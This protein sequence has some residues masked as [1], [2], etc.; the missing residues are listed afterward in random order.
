MNH[1]IFKHIL[2]TAAC[3]VTLGGV[4]LSAGCAHDPITRQAAGGSDSAPGSTAPATS[5]DASAGAVGSGVERYLDHLAAVK[6]DGSKEPATLGPQQASTQVQWLDVRPAEAPSATRAVPQAASE[7]SNT[8][9]A[10]GSPGTP[11]SSSPATSGETSGGTS[12]ETV[13]LASVTQPQPAATGDPVVVIQSA[14][15]RTPEPRKLEPR[16]PEPVAKATQAPPQPAKTSNT[17]SAVKQDIAPAPKDDAPRLKDAA[18]L[19]QA[20]R[21]ATHNA[22][23]QT[24]EQLA[25]ELGLTAPKLPG[26]DDMAIQRLE[27]CQR[28]SGFGVYDPFPSLSFAAG[29]EQKMIVYVELDK[30]KPVPANGDYLETRIMQTIELYNEADGTVVW[31]EQPAEVVDRSRNHRRDFFVVQMVTLPAQLAI[32]RYRLK[33]RVTDAH[34]GEIAE[35]T[36]SLTLASGPAIAPS[37]PALGAGAIAAQPTPMDD[38]Q[39]R[40]LREL[41]RVLGSN[42][43]KGE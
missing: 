27:L 41:Q 22:D 31:R 36:V 11:G 13:V 7:K 29:R 38:E 33:V 2:H 37:E 3:V 6:I 28:V 42:A 39:A 24:K 14:R 26:E 17:K 30:F 32:G 12:G 10:P 1:L 20:I 15:P 34:S 23:D 5:R 4:L 18:Q 8:P 35:K 9:P 40:L 19:L 21:K 16:K 25:R 43:M